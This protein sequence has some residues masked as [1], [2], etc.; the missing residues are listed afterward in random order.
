MRMIYP[1]F[2]DQFYRFLF[3]NYQIIT[4]LDFFSYFLQMQV[5]VFKKQR[6]N[7]Q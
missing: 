2:P 1:T 7:F 5:F 3:Q 6:K 4:G